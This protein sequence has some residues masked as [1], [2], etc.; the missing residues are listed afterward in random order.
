MYPSTPSVDTQ[1][2][3]TRRHCP[4]PHS[5]PMDVLVSQNVVTHNLDTGRITPGMPWAGLLL[6]LLL[7][8]LL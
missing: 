8:L 2:T 3:L 4:S 6:L 7:L 5:P 1:H